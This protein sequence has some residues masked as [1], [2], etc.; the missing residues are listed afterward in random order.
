MTATPKQGF[1]LIGW[2]CDV[3]QKQTITVSAETAQNCQPQFGADDDNDGIANVVEDAGPNAGDADHDG[4]PDSQQTSQTAPTGDNT[5]EPDLA[6]VTPPAQNPSSSQSVSS[7]DQGSTTVTPR[8]GSGASSSFQQGGSA[9]HPD[10]VSTGNQPSSSSQPISSQEEMDVTGANAASE[11][12]PSSSSQS[13]EEK[14]ERKSLVVTLKEHETLK[15]TLGE[16]QGVLFIKA[17]PDPALVLVDAWKPFGNGEGEL[18]L[19][20]RQVGETE[21][22]V[23]DS[24]SSQ[25]VT[26]YIKVIAN[27]SV[28][29]V[30]PV[31]PITSDA[32]TGTLNQILKVGQSVA[33]TLNNGTGIASISEIPD[34][35]LISLEAWTPLGEGAVKFMLT[36]RNVGNTK[37]VITDTATKPHKTILN[38]TVIEGE[39]S[40]VTTQATGDTTNQGEQNTGSDQQPTDVTLIP[41]GPIQGETPAV[42]E[43]GL[44]TGGVTIIDDEIMTDDE[45]IIDDETIPPQD[46][47]VK[48]ATDSNLEAPKPDC[49]DMNA[50]G[51]D[52]EGY[53]VATQACFTN[54]VIL[55]EEERPT[56]RRM[57]THTEAQSIDISAT[58]TIDPR[59]VG[60]AADILIVGLYATLTEHFLFTRDFIN[61]AMWDGQINTIPVARYYP[62]LPEKIEFFIYDGPVA[63]GEFMLIVAYRLKTGTIIHNRLSPLHFWVGNS[64]SI[65]GRIESPKTPISNDINARSFFETIVYQSDGTRS[66]KPSFA[67]HD[68]LKLS[69]WLRVDS[70]HVG[71]QADIIVIALHQFD[72]QQT[73]YSFDGSRWQIDELDS[74]TAVDTYYDQLPAQLE[75]PVA[76]N[77]L[78]V[79]GGKLTVYV[80]YRLADGVIVFN[81]IAPLQLLVNE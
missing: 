21:M 75:I 14:S 11:T 32:E 81:G 33:L 70:R 77:T 50:L 7:Q 60:Q 74:L 18:I 53:S 2:T 1:A 30:K 27:D 4:I 17:I 36:G 8:P 40:Q 71:Q 72:K 44:T 52:A 73:V 23:N 37:L 54:R 48:P 19:T 66:H 59:H 10:S 25:Q 61:W 5:T 46:T 80:G 39:A 6:N 78:A 49:D 76:L 24:R 45:A 31:E 47:V 68:N 69:T 57:L 51:F 65:D 55:H 42:T 79:K 43:G 58:I 62:Q 13:V 28:S 67:Y 64:A 35:R 9:T 20:G 22:I 15:M 63:P 16:G 34:S 41:N 12:R 26:L 3:A 29:E 56:Q 38:I